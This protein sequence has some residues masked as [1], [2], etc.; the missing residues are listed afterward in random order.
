MQ[1]HRKDMD[2]VVMNK[3]LV[4]EF[5][6]FAAKSY[7]DDRYWL[8]VWMHAKD[9][10]CV[11]KYLIEHWLS[12]HTISYFRHHGVQDLV[13]FG[14]LLGYLHDIGK[15]TNVFQC[16][17]AQAIPGFWG[18]CA[19]HGVPLYS[20]NLS[21]LVPHNLASEYIVYRRSGNQKF[22][23]IVGGHHGDFSDGVE[24][25]LQSRCT[26]FVGDTKQKNVVEAWGRAWKQMYEWSLQECNVTQEELTQLSLTAEEEM[27]LVGLLIQADWIASNSHYFGL[28]RV[29]D[30]GFSINYEERVAKAIELLHL[31][32][33]MESA[34]FYDTLTDE[35]FETSFGFPMNEVQRMVVETLGEIETPG[36]MILE[37]P[38]GVGKTEAALAAADICMNNTAEMGGLYFGLPTQ[39]TANGIFARLTTW[40]KQKSLGQEQSIMLAHGN[41]RLNESFRDICDNPK[42]NLFVND[43]CSGKKQMLLSDFVF[44]TIDQLLFAGLKQRHVMLRHLGLSGKVVVVDEV[45]A[46]DA[47]MT[48]FLKS[49][50][51]WLSAYQVP[52]LL[53]S[54]TLPSARRMDL[55]KAYTHVKT[56]RDLES[57]TVNWST[58]EAYPLLTYTEGKN[59]HQKTCT[60]SSIR[61]LDIHMKQ[62]DEFGL[63]DLLKDLLKDG[64][65]AAV[66]VN[67][68]AD[69]QRLAQSLHGIYEDATVLLLH[70]SFTMEHRAR[71][72]KQVLSYLDKKSTKQMRHRVVLVG[73]QVLEQSLDYDVDYM[74]SQLC[75]MD[76][77]L[78]RMGR[79]WRHS[80]R[81]EERPCKE[82]V[83]YI[84]EMEKDKSGYIYDKYLLRKTKECLP[85]MMH[86]PIDISHYVQM[87]YQEQTGVLDEDYMNWV[88]KQSQAEKD[89]T[90]ACLGYA[91][92]MV[93]CHSLLQRISVEKSQELMSVRDGGIS[94]VPI[95][96][97]RLSEDTICLLND[98]TVSWCL[99]DPLSTSDIQTLLTQTLSLPYRCVCTVDRVEE[100]IAELE[101]MS[102]P[103]EA[104]RQK[105]L[106]LANELFLVFDEN[107]QVNLNKH[108]WEYHS[109]LGFVDRTKTERSS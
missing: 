34:G 70:S 30:Y 55:V 40:A 97:K 5:Y 50:L 51:S 58:N 62:V 37:A 87:V 101:D 100:V 20:Q 78:Q 69:A 76:L 75:P 61:P 56:E 44:G 105:Y 17:I 15:L 83:F 93:T 31:P 7:K 73:T 23:E 29:N 24:M 66:I 53:L 27:L 33:R 41:A 9:T 81:D 49:V 48:M 52:V 84:L 32:D 22:A 67:T 1:E 86:L 103:M 13:K 99:T 106:G 19:N 2:K 90:G 80:H 63:S 79:M 14:Q 54:A 71:L 72:E 10:G 77:L 108:Q 47:R 45:H 26:D 18:D 94:V 95:C 28:I 4:S 109:Q 43:F 96:V 60:V 64:G 11:M 38:M 35:E 25:L 42:D 102:Q 21:T 59:V 36:L 65:C 104:W 91:E 74:I 12:S 98:D 46:Y 57:D 89:A 6:W 3:D 92:E 8:P 107:N 68:V 82:P 88:L 16:R 39:A 85:L